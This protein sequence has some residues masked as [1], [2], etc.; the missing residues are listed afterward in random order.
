MKQMNNPLQKHNCGLYAIICVRVVG[1]GH[2][3]ALQCASTWP[4][5][6][7]LCNSV[8]LCVYYMCRTY[9]LHIHWLH[10]YYTCIPIYALHL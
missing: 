10:M 3:S 6:P 5:V 4:V 1:Q 2:L 7:H 8:V 9:E